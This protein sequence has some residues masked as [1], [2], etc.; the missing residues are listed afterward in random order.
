MDDLKLRMPFYANHE[1]CEWLKKYPRPIITSKAYPEWPTS[2]A[3]PIKEICHYFGLPLGVSMYSTPDYMIALAIYEGATHIDMFGVDMV[4]ASKVEEM[5]SA[6]AM[7]IG[8]AHARGVKVT[9]FT[10]SFYMFY[11]IRA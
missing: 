2:E 3:F 10:G 4:E 9:T 5:R 11:T 1:F 7:W 8:A 6:T